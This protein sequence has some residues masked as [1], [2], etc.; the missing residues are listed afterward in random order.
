MVPENLWLPVEQQH[1]YLFLRHPETDQPPRLWADRDQ[2]SVQHYDAIAARRV[3]RFENRL[4]RRA[5]DFLSQW[6]RPPACPTLRLFP[7][8]SEERR[9]IKL[10]EPSA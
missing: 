2:R 1:Q 8:N 5:P 10:C 4:Q 6:D 7:P 3:R 9:I